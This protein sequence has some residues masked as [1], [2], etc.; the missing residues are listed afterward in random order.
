MSNFCTCHINP[1][2]CK[3][4]LEGVNPMTTETNKQLFDKVLQRHFPTETNA[5]WFKRADELLTAVVEMGDG[6]GK[7]KEGIKV[8]EWLIQ[9]A[10]LAQELDEEKEFFRR[11]S[12]ELKTV[13]NILIKENAHLR[14]ALQFYADKESYVV[15]V[16]D[17]WEPIFPV[18]QDD[19]ETARKVLKGAST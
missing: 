11:N 15:N 14:E 19:G 7:H 3:W 16:T 6:H 18:L 10:K 1:K 8:L 13:E 2:E 17:Q 4:C 12:V 9:R 5:E